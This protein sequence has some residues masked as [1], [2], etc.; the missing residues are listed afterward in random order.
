MT[1]VTLSAR[2]REAAQALRGAL[3]HVSHLIKALKVRQVKCVVPRVLVRER[4]VREANG[5]EAAATAA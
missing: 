4:A 5:R 1:P 2:G 3:Q